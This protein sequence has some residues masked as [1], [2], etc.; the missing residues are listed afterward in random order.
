VHLAAKLES[1][2]LIYV[3]SS[4]IMGYDLKDIFQF[5]GLSV[6]DTARASIAMLNLPTAP[7]RSMHNL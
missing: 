3:L 4:K 6:T 7:S 5:Y 1:S 2:D